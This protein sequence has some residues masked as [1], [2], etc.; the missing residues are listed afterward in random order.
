VTLGAG[1]AVPALAQDSIDPVDPLEDQALAEEAQARF[2]ESLETFKMAFETAVQQAASGSGEVRQ[3][4]RARA[5][6]LLEKIDHLT[7]MVT[8]H[9]GTE[10]YLSGQDAEALGPVLKGQVDW[11]RARYL[12]A[13]G[14]VEQAEALAA[15][16]GIVRDWW[17]IGPFDNERGRGFGVANPPEKGVDLNGVY[18]GKERKVSW[19]RVPVRE[20]LGGVNLDALLRPN[21]Q[22]AAYAVAF[23]KSDAERSAALRLGSDEAAK[24]WWN[25][26]QVLERDVRRPIAFDQDVVGVV[27][28]EGW[29]VLL[30]KVC[31]QTGPWAFRARLTAP[32]GSALEGVS[33]ATSREDADAAL[34]AAPAAKAFEGE[35][36]GGA[37]SFYEGL[38]ERSSARDLFHLGYLHHRREFDAVSDR[39]AENLLKQAAELDPENAIY[40]FH[41]A[42]AAAPPIEMAV[43][44]EENRQ[45]IGREK[46]LELDPGYAVAYHALAAYYTTSLSNLDRAEQLLR[47]ALEINP[48]YYEAR[49]DLAGVLGRR[50]LPSA[51]ELERKKA[52][53]TA[54]GQGEESRARALARELDRTGLSHEALGA[55]KDVLALD[56]RS[57]GV[58]RRVAELAL[59]ALERDEAMAVLADIRRHD[60]FDTQSL[61]RV[62]ELHEGA[63]D[64]DAAA[65]VLTEAL[66]VAP[67]DDTLLAALGRVHLKADRHE[68]ALTAFREALRVN[69]KRQELERYVEFLDPA[70][71]PFEDDYAVDI[72][73]L[74]EK[75]RDYDNAENDGWIVLLDQVLDKVNPDGTSS[76]YIHMAA[77]ILTEAGVK[78]F[79]RYF[80]QSWRGEAFKWKKARVIKP[81]GSVVEAKTQSGR[82]FRFADFPPL[83]P[84]DVIDVAYRRDQREQSFFGDYF[85]NVNY[86]ADQVPMM[87][88][89]YTL[90][91]PASR[92]F[93]FHTQ[94]LNVEPTVTTSEDGETRVYQWTVEDSPKIRFEP[95]MPAATELYPQVQV[96]TYESWDAFAKWWWS[97]IRDQHIASDDVKAKVAE[98]IEGK[99]TRL[100]KVRAI[101]QFVTDEITYQAWSFGVH[102]YKPYTTT[103]IFD[104]REGDCKDKAI[105]FNTMLQEIG[106]E[107]YPVLIRAEQSRNEQ[108]MSLAM[109][110]Q[111]NH[112]IS[113]VPDVDGNGTGMF[114]DGTAQY[115]S[116]GPPP[117]MDRGAHVLVVKPDGGELV[118]IPF[119]TPDYQGLDQRWTITVDADGSAEIEGELTFRGDFSIQ[120]R[121]MFAV[122]GQRPLIL[123]AMLAQTFG[124]VRLLENEFD[125]LTDYTEASESFRVKAKVENFAKVSGEQRTLPTQFVDFFGGMLGQLVQRPEREHDLLLMDPMSM[126]TQATYH[127]PAGWTVTAAPEDVDLSIEEAAFTSTATHDGGTL[128][129]E[130]ILELRSHRIPAA[131]YGGFRDGLIKVSTLSKQNWTVQPGEAADDAGT[132]EDA[133]DDEAGA[134]PGEDK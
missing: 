55:W 71:A 103:S 60:P 106:V 113:Y 40:R 79:D 62:A 24:A 118:Q 18:D 109:V 97:M 116:M 114:L 65:A 69:P 119:G 33:V 95:A 10:T 75:A 16:L 68:D 83:E 105:L 122:A 108:D 53:E 132:D 124:R 100:E 11:A 82:G 107:S 39:R 102:G 70:A 4:N 37:K 128:T 17:V 77:K 129:L 130:R 123:Q 1:L 19:R 64:L 25:G 78:R 85:G 96:T 120:A 117:A 52:L 112:C 43:E 45:R 7:E 90:V 28:N 36:D 34:A 6:V 41:Y 9:G 22:A 49:L 133:G 5:E 58:R 54:R 93:Y 127:L 73:P 81:D 94:N 72:A 20:P 56:A 131:S 87:L 8:R 51:A 38:S 115:A 80:A 47:Q 3:A 27:L 121:S 76:T 35:V 44:K 104:K 91:T 26:A 63:G 74:V 46:A 42:E 59:R 30:L 66:A 14:S 31:D 12:L 126:R 84:G 89:T 48:D 29:N 50:G 92:D 2:E 61:A 67:E 21:D 99:E 88:S 86:F 23:V 32:D 110:N 13:G 98:L 125:D 101:Y 134:A 15:G 57:N 111:F